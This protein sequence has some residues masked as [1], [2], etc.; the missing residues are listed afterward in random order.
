M[1]AG[2][3]MASSA[4][5]MST[6]DRHTLTAIS[7]TSD[8]LHCPWFA[9]GS[10]ERHEGEKKMHTERMLARIEA[11]RR[12]L[13]EQSGI[14]PIDELTSEQLIAAA[15]TA[16]N[17][18]LLEHA[19]MFLDRLPHEQCDAEYLRVLGHHCWER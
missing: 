8:A 18:G 12:R 11:S 17:A 14:T 16:Y 3:S 2:A 5:C 19:A 7:P 15:E 6:L 9:M 10:H 1:R 4:R 13:I